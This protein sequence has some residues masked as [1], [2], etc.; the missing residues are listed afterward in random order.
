LHVVGY[1]GLGGVV[2]GAEAGDYAG[3]VGGGAVLVELALAFEAGDGELEADDGFELAVDVGGGGV[4]DFPGGGEGGLVEVG[5][6]GDDV[7]EALGVVEEGDGAV[8][9]DGGVVPGGDD[10][11]G[12]LLGGIPVGGDVG[13]GAGEDEEGFGG[14]VGGLPL[15]VGAGDVAEDG[16]VGAA[17]S[18]RRMG[19]W[20][21]TR[22]EE[23]RVTRAAKLL[24]CMSAWRVGRS[25]TRKSLGVYMRWLRRVAAGL[26]ILAAAGGVILYKS[27]SRFRW[28]TSSG[29]CAI[30]GS[31]HYASLRSR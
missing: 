20:V 17:V 22:P 9:V 7:A 30:Q 1:G 24:R 11:V 18:S 28:E 5:E 3:L 2:E 14:G 15:E 29:K 13:V 31:L 10:A 6:A 26:M 21:A 23:V 16:A 8:G 25:S 19:R 27:S 4:G 12:F